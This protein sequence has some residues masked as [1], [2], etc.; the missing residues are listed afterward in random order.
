MTLSSKHLVCLSRV[1]FSESDS[2]VTVENEKKLRWGVLLLLSLFLRWFSSYDKT[3]YN[4]VY[5]FT[6]TFCAFVS[7]LI[8]Y[9][10][11]TIL[12]TKYQ[13]GIKTTHT[14]FVNIIFATGAWLKQPVYVSIGQ[15]F[16][17]EIYFPLL[18]ELN[19]F[20]PSPF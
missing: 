16:G 1:F 12:F 2:G 18:S 6:N 20:R 13:Q 4:Y 19:R 17:W 15:R 5:A 7:L 3:E 11:L 10:Q 14:C 8:N 9:I